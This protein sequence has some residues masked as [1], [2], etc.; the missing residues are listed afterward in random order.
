MG[1]VKRG[2]TFL[3]LVVVMMLFGI[4][5]TIVVPNLQQLL[6]AYKR[7][8]FLTQISALVRLTWQ[9]SLATQTAHRVYFDLEKRLLRIEKETDTKD[10]DGN[11]AFAPAEINYLSTSYQWDEGI[12]IKQFYIEGEELLTRAG[13][14]TEKV[15]FYIAPDGLA[16]EVVINLVDSGDFDEQ[17]KPASV[18]LVLNPFSAEFKD[19]DEFQKPA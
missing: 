6:P 2:F 19:Y 5:A 10:K 18:G 7:K 9:Q 3:E 4:V 1:S 12:V 16:Q 13:I 11:P 14:K 17:G 15:W 8:E